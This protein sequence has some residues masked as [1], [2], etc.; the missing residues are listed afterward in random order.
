[1]IDGSTR[2]VTATVPVGKGPVGV[3]VDPGTHTVYVTTG[4]RRQPRVLL[5]RRHGGGDRRGDA[6]CHRHRVRRR[7]HA[8]AWR[9]TRAPT[10]STSPPATTLG[11]GD[12]RVDAHRHRHRARRRVAGRRG[13]GPGQP[14]RLRHHRRRPVSVIDGSTRTVTATVPVGK[15]PRPDFAAGRPYDLAVDP[16]THTVYV[17][18]DSNDTVS[19]IDGATRTVTATCP[20]PATR[21]RFTGWRWTRAPIPSTSHRRRHGVGDRTSIVVCIG[22][23]TR[24]ALSDDHAATG[25]AGELTLSSSAARN[26]P[27]SGVWAS[28]RATTSCWK[29]RTSPPGRAPIT[30]R[31]RD[32][33]RRGGRDKSP[34]P[35]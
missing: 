34:R 29:A 28:R 22:V 26:G 11:V 20:C 12:R 13:G 31:D 27:S 18:Y 15:N 32:P 10:P 21:P 1:M 16:G 17:T 35:S 6:H 33:T 14:H 4:R 7:R 2:T 24:R 23:W 9:W 8:R 3:A 5:R 25:P 30:R 19:V